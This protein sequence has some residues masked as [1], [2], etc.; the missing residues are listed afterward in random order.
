MPGSSDCLEIARLMQCVT[1]PIQLRLQPN[2]K[3]LLHQRDLYFI[4]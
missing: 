4:I 3:N 1:V 2:I